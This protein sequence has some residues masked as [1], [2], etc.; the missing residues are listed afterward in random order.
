[1]SETWVLGDGQGRT[2]KER[3]EIV[4]PLRQV[5]WWRG[6]NVPGPC[7]LAKQ[8]RKHNEGKWRV[9]QALGGRGREGTGLYSGPW[10]HAFHT[11]SQYR[12]RG[13]GIPFCSKR[14]SLQKPGG[15][16]DRKNLQKVGL[17]SD[18]TLYKHLG[19]NPSVRKWVPLLSIA[20]SHEGRQIM[21]RR[22]GKKGFLEQVMS[23]LGADS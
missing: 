18:I 11:Q 23:G 7:S 15:A 21:N 20:Y 3:G 14:F 19:T 4:V 16:Q 17:F 6:G 2:G 12:G 5:L 22:E 8:E 9:W 10:A 1:M 13:A